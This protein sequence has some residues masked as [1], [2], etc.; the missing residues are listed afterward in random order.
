[1]LGLS[2]IISLITAALVYFALNGLLVQP[3]MRITR[4]MLRF[5]QNPED[6]SRIIVPVRGAMTRSAPPSASSRTCKTS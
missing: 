4:N 6:A 3:M 2:I 1:M 5:S